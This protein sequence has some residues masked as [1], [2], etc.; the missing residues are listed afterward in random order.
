MKSL[1]TSATLSAI[2]LLGA[3]WPALGEPYR[4]FTDVRTRATA[5]TTVIRA[6]PNATAPSFRLLLL[7]SGLADP[8][9][10]GACEVWI[11]F[12]DRAGTINHFGQYGKRSDSP[13]EAPPNR[14]SLVEGPLQGDDFSS[15][16]FNV[17]QSSLGEQRP[18]WVATRTNDALEIVSA[19]VGA[20]ANGACVA[21]V[22]SLFTSD[23][24]YRDVVDG[25][26][27]T[28][29]GEVRLRGFPSQNPSFAIFLEYA[30]AGT[31]IDQEGDGGFMTL[32]EDA[33][34]MWLELGPTAF[35]RQPTGWETPP[36]GRLAFLAAGSNDIPVDSHFPHSFTLAESS[37]GEILR[38][39]PA[40]I[41]LSTDECRGN[42]RLQYATSV[43]QFYR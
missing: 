3:T 34:I 2:L 43:A 26:R 37:S 42:T 5:G 16:G 32:T 31:T 40:E 22:R 7:S 33:C 20:D 36:G 25:N 13:N 23:L 6:F 19:D 14:R 9:S 15:D 24:A 35:L 17:A 1:I 29:Y 27:L 4:S 11:E 18:H 21:G 41:S 8:N 30:E 12:A 28:E 10:H 39:G 38:I